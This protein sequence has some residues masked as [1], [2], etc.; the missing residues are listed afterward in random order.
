MSV[1]CIVQVIKSR[2]MMWAGHVA[3]IVERRGVYKI[4]VGKP[5]G[6]RQLGRPRRKW[7][8]NIKMDI[9]DVR[10]E[11]M[12]WVDVAQDRDRWRSVVNVAMKCSVSQYRP[13]YSGDEEKSGLRQSM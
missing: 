2:G 7:D 11:G 6:K 1:L 10:C 3:R 5:E 4:L 9:Q 12:D 8:D 13:I